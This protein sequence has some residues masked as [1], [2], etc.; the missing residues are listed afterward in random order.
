MTDYSKPLYNDIAHFAAISGEKPYQTYTA[1]IDYIAGWLDVTGTPVIGWRYDKEQNKMFHE[2]LRKTMTATGTAMYDR[3]CGWYDLF[4][5]IFMEH[6][7]NKDLRGQCFTPDG[8]ANLC[9]RILMDNATEAATMPCGWFGEKRVAN[10]PA[11]GSGRMLLAAA[12]YMEKQHD[13]YIYVIGEDIDT[14]CVKQTAINLAL[15]GIYGEV[16]CHDTLKDPDGMRFGYIVNEW[17]YPD[18]HGR[19]SLR[20]SENPDDF[21]GTRLWKQMRNATP[22]PKQHKQPVQLSLFD[23]DNESN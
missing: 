10:D 14:T 11:C 6:L 15:H 5:D 21:V 19:P 18:R 1:L 7:A 4:G 16:I 3:E 8:A 22:E 23:Y 2:M 9:A 20:Y 13:E 12:K 17:I